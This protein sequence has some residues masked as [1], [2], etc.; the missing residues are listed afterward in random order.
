MLTIISLSLIKGGL[1]KRTPSNGSHRRAHIQQLASNGSHRT[2]NHANVTDD[3]GQPISFAVRLLFTEN[4][5]VVNVPDCPRVIPVSD[6]RHTPTSTDP[7]D[8]LPYTV[9]VGG[10]ASIWRDAARAPQPHHLLVTPVQLHRRNIQRRLR[11]AALPRSAFDFARLVDVARNV[12]GAART[13]TD[14][15]P[16]TESLDR[17]DRLA[18][19]RRLLRDPS[20]AARDPLER[21]V[22]SPASE[23]A[24]TIERARVGLEMV[25]GF[26]PARIDALDA[27]I[28]DLNGAARADARDLVTGLLALQT[29]LDDR[30]EA[31][32]SETD[33]LRIAS[34]LVATEPDVWPAAYGEIETLSVGG[35]SMLTASLED[36][37]ATVST[38]TDVDV[39]LYLRHGT[40]PQ[41]RTQLA[42]REGPFTPGEVRP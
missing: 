23:Y 5:V 11:E 38:E 32:V 39:H 27:T 7:G 21:V 1:M 17:I 29:E 26:H 3:A 31:T 16:E 4:D 18:L 22:G 35:I 30:A 9:H 40:G 24:E 37:L 41:I 33:L 36:F 42:T 19:I 8:R 10:S 14:T 2:D 34:S 13:V 6:R 28:D 15:E 25:T 12:N 20:S